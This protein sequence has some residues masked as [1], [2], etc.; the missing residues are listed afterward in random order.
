MSYFTEPMGHASVLLIRAV[1]ANISAHQPIAGG[2][3]IWHRRTRNHCMCNLQ[4]I[5]QPITTE[6]KLYIALILSLKV[7]HI[8]LKNCDL[9]R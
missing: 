5:N 7:R 4:Y 6:N 1:E 8:C 3:T 2:Y 9:I